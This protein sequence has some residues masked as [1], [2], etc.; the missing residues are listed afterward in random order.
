MVR[1]PVCRSAGRLRDWPTPLIKTHLPEDML[2]AEWRIEGQISAHT[3]G[4]N[5]PVASHRILRYD[6]PL[7]SQKVRIFRSCGERVSRGTVSLWCGPIVKPR[8][9]FRVGGWERQPEMHRAQDECR[10]SEVSP[11]IRGPSTGPRRTE[12]VAAPFVVSLSNH[13]AAETVRAN[14]AA[15]LRFGAIVGSDQRTLWPARSRPSG[16]IAPIWVQG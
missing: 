2:G 14:Y 7:E 12:R 11:G 5:G 9:T 8:I 6:A 1:P 13:S 16:Q 10:E 15:H 4:R 3:A